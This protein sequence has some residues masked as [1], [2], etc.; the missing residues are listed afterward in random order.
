MRNKVEVERLILRTEYDPYLEMETILACFPDD[1]ANPGR[2]AAVPM[3]FMHDMVFFDCYTEVNMDY[4]YES[5]KPLKDEMLA[6]KCKMELEKR[7]SATFKIVQ[8]IMR[9]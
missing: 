9:R 4:Y 1:P 2:I 7:Y 3:R 8:K 5:A 6:E